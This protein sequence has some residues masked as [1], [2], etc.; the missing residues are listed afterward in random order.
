MCIRDRTIR[1]IISVKKIDFVKP[2]D[3]RK[4]AKSLLRDLLREVRGI[5]PSEIAKLTDKL[6]EEFIVPELERVMKN[7]AAA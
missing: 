4:L 7:V 5:K 3:K 1:S 2:S 6:V